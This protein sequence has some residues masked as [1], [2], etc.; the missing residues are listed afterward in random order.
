MRANPAGAI[1]TVKGLVDYLPSVK[2]L[3]F[4]SIQDAV[5]SSIVSVKNEF[6]HLEDPA[7]LRPTYQ[8]GNEALD[9][10]QK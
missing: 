7:E 8:L 1:E 2:D 9:F 10:D 5:N 6:S 3:S 4:Q